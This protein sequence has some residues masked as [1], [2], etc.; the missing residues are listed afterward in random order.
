MLPPGPRSPALWQ[1]YRFVATPH[2]YATGLQKKYGD[3]VT[4][5]SLL[6]RGVAVLEAGLAREVFAAP[7]E[8]FETVSLL[9]ALFGSSAVIAVSGEKHKK[10]RKLVNPRFHGAQVKGFLAG[11]Q[12]ALRA[13]L[14]TFAGAA[15]SG[16]TVV[17]ADVTQ[18]MTLDVIIETV[19]GAGD[20]DRSVAREVLLDAIHGLAPSIV[21]GRTFHK[22]WFP[23]WR[24]FVRARE[25][26]DRWVDGVVG[27]R[28]AQGAGAVGDDVLGVLLS[29][30]YE[31]G[32]PMD[33]SEVRDQLFTLLLA[34]HETSAVATA[35]SVYYLLRNPR[36]IERLRGEIDALGPD[37]APEAI[38]KL[39]YL[40][41]VVS[42]TL[43]IEPVVTDVIRI[44]REP[45]TIGGRWTVPRGHVLSVVLVA[46]LRDARV[47]AEPDSFRP[48]RFLEQKFAPNEFLPFGGGARRCLGAAFAQAE[49]A[50]AVA[51]IASRWELELAT[52][53]PERAIRRNLTMGP[54]DGV[55]LRVLGPRSR[56]A[57][58][59]PPPGLRSG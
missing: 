55:R 10:L 51:E 21:G 20:L 1:T 27:E 52:A 9:E 44:C 57:A 38:T 45:I 4:F 5:R 34:G 25:A 42:E 22:P 24:R 15:E 48:E 13:H 6:G 17:M 11:M 16:K 28:R 33:D 32:S 39:A 53:E 12:R 37:P 31:D 7:P 2:A 30:R 49:L 3:A 41:A 56:A 36:A 8:T 58:A 40:G 43:R 54:K 46:I 19:F 18:A 29:A 14:A 23:P 26:F 59:A 47:F 35:W 50:I